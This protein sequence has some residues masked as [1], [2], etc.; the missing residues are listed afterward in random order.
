MS[1]NFK[2][3]ASCLPQEDVPVDD[4]HTWVGPD[5]S[6]PFRPRGGETPELVPTPF[7]PL[8]DPHIQLKELDPQL[9]DS[10]PVNLLLATADSV[11]AV[12]Q[13]GVEID[14]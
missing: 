3:N 6:G 11:Q 13:Q 8:D 4:P 2:N 14:W 10:R 5:V 12:G 7:G 1:D 9:S